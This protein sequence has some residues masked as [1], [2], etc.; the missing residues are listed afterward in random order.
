MTQLHIDLKA[1]A[2]INAAWAFGG[3]VS[4]APLLLRKDVRRHLQLCRDELGFQHVRCDGM[5]SDAMGV[6]RLDGS[7][8]FTAVERALDGLMEAGVMPFLRLTDPTAT[9]DARWYERVKALA[10]M[11]DERYGC[12]ARE[13]HFEVPAAGG[14][15][16]GEDYLRRYD[17]AVRAIKEVHAEF[18]VGGPGVGGAEALDAFLAHVAKGHFATPSTEEP[19]A[20]SAAARCDFI[21]VDAGQNGPA[22][23][24]GG[25]AGARRAA[26]S[27]L[28][29][30][31]AAVRRKVTDALGENVPL[32]C[33]GWDRVAGTARDACGHAAYVAEM[34]A[35]VSESAQG[36][37]YGTASDIGDGSEAGPFRFEAFH[38][39]R[40]LLTVNEIRKAAFHAFRLLG[41]HRGYHCERLVTTWTDPVEG[42]GCLASVEEYTLRLLCWYHRDT[43]ASATEAPTTFI[44]EGLPQSVH[45]AQVEVIRPGA[46]SAYEAWTELGRPQFVNLQALDALEAASRPG[47]AEVD[48]R[49]YP[50]RLQPGMVVQFTIPL[51]FEETW[52]D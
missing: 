52:A 22:G 14:V 10:T 3:S 45:M 2:P 24:N 9:D 12:D 7:C 13:W 28:R 31:L 29:E 49:E 8:D 36:S 34:A 6:F 18:R 16:A 33:G 11:I 20:A 17:S 4:H 50:P 23:P 30:H 48:F 35:A 43:P 40:G 39:G 27:E 32:I 5:L 46:G 1:R 38:G 51:P 26:S 37:L 21:T 41:E 19:H 47:M 15:E 44:I 25:E 42:V